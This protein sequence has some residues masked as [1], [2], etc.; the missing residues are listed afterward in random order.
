MGIRICFSFEWHLPC[1]HG[2]T[3]ELN[4]HVC[5]QHG[6]RPFASRMH[7]PSRFALM[8]ATFYQKQSKGTRVTP[9][10][11]F[12][13]RHHFRRNIDVFPAR[14]GSCALSILSHTQKRKMTGHGRSEDR[15]SCMQCRVWAVPHHPTSVP[16][17]G[18]DVAPRCT[19]VLTREKKCFV[20]R[21]LK[22]AGLERSPCSIALTVVDYNR[23]GEREEGRPK[24]RS[25]AS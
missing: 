13:N 21:S 17:E 15:C 23:S 10:A 6:P 11:T 20:K 18:L 19:L 7:L 4:L 3:A 12:S 8:G 24:L 2:R 14:K 1:P 16:V 22:P 5:R 25:S 9:R